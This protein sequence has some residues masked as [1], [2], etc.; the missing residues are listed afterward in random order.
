M[1]SE[2]HSSGHI[3]TPRNTS[4]PCDLQAGPLHV[5]EDRDLGCHVLDSEPSMV[6][7]QV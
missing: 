1:L 6:L 2:T 3:K 5:T 4:V 7:S